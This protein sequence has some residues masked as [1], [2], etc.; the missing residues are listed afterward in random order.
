MTTKIKPKTRKMTAAEA[1]EA[2]NVA[3]HDPET[4]VVEHLDIGQGVHQGDVYL[5]R[6]ADDWP[7]GKLMGTRQVAV[8]TS[9]GSRHIAE[10]ETVEVFEGKK[11]PDFVTVP[12]WSEAAEILGP[13]VK[14]P[15]GLVL[16]HPEHAHHDIRQAGTYQVINQLD[17]A[18]RRRVQD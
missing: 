5:L 6:V 4:R 1:V 12:E 9:I 15:H 11:L 13:V 8:G 16:T 14:A 7:M 10:G 2:V 18:T 3:A 17:Y